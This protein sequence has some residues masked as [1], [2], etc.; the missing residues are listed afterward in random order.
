M[1][2]GTPKGAALRWA[3]WAAAQDTD[4]CLCP[5]HPR[6]RFPD[7]R[8]RAMHVAVCI[9]AHGERPAGKVVAHVCVNDTHG[10]FVCGNPRHV[11]WATQAENLADRLTRGTSPVGERNP[12]AVLTWTQVD[13]IRRLHA[14]GQPQSVLA[15]QFAVSRS[16]IF[17]VV[18][19]KTWRLP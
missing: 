4:E 6:V 3:T 19:A 2:K 13:E 9:L 7:G 17:G 12:A 16:T 10:E 5:P 1:R 8:N 15:E 18:H 14:A 11:R